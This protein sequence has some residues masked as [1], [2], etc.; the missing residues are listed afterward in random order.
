MSPQGASWGVV[1][2]DLAVKNVRGLRVVDA[3]VL[4]SIA[5]PFHCV[6]GLNSLP[7]HLRR[8]LIVKL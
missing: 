2:P 8:V 4:A 5:N 6:L 3:S 7:S 1:D